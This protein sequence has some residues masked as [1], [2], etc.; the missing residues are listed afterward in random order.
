MSMFMSMHTNINTESRYI[1]TSTS[2][3]TLTNT[4]TSTF[5]SMVTA[6]ILIPT[7]TTIRATMDRTITIIRDMKVKRILMPIEKRSSTRK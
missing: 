2:M 4:T 5:M 6:R 3:L 7:I 1:Y